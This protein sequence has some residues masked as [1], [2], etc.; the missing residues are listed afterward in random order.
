MSNVQ[1]HEVFPENVLTSYGEFDNVDFVMTY[2]GRKLQ[3]NSIRV[4]FDIEVTPAGA[5][6]INIESNPDLYFDGKVGAHG[7]IDSIITS[8]DGA[9]IE[10]M[11]S[12]GRLVSMKTK[13]T[14]N[15]NEMNTSS[16]SCEGKVLN[17]R[18]TRNLLA[19]VPA[20]LYTANA[21]ATTTNYLTSIV[22]PFNVAVKPDFCLNNTFSDSGGLPLVSFRKSGV[23]QVSLRLARNYSF[24]YGENAQ[25][26]SY[27][28][29]NLR[30]T[31]ISRLDDGSD[32]TL[33]MRSVVG[34]KQ[35]MA[36]D[37]ANIQ[38]IV[39]AVC[40]AVSVSVQPQ[41]QENQSRW[42]NYQL[43]KVPLFKQVQY[44]FNDSTNQYLT[45][46]L[47]SEP[48]SI[49]RYIDS[50]RSTGMNSASLTSLKANLAYG[51]GLHFGSYV[52]LMNQ[53][54]NIQLTSGIGQSVVPVGHT[55]AGTARTWIAYMY[56][57]TL[58]SM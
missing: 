12:Y 3:L 11:T 38:A 20:G 24:L 52:P 43:H 7:V 50:F 16:N 42:N 40:N 45:F 53:K 44:L 2:E 1:Y 33:S 30:M 19:G 58:I 23:I 46:I 4:L 18:L 36:S 22:T 13:A 57:H 32:D 9:V 51:L 14:T 17:D 49:E 47:K 55:N 35:S 56:F 41:D 28:L 29:K 6:L 8:V 34:I 54:F 10:N 48:E 39:P 15:P 37:Y 5:N 27:S 21:D 26:A 31:Y 25:G